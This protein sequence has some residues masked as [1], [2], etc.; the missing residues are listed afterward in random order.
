M[1]ALCAA[2]LAATMSMPAMAQDASEPKSADIATV[3][4]YNEQNEQLGEASEIVVSDAGN[5]QGLVVKVSDAS[6]SARE[7]VV[8]LER[9]KNA[10]NRTIVV[11]A[12]KDEIKAM[13]K[14]QD[15]IP[16]MGADEL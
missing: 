12:T 2:L 1:R 15:T 13:P 3:Q 10:S 7:V 9:V 16:D 14:L 4:V 5:V 8:P 11:A 6:A